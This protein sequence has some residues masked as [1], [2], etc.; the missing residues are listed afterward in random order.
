M[1]DFYCIQLKKIGLP[2][3]IGI[4]DFERAGAQPML[5]SVTLLLSPPTRPDDDISSVVDYDIVRQIILELTTAQHWELQESLCANIAEHLLS[6]DHILG[7]IVKSEKTDVYPD[8]QSVGCLLARL[9][10][11]FPA[12][13]PWW[14][15]TV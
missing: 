13:F 5:F 1:T 7:A 15:L 9:G 8:T 6:R 12:D 3:S 11:S 10:P 14:S 4:H 2:V